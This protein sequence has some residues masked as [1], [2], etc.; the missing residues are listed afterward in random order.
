MTFSV[1]SAIDRHVGTLEKERE[2]DGKWHPSSISGCARQAVYNFRGIPRTDER[3]PKSKRILRIGH[4]LHQF[5]QDAVMAEVGSTIK[6]FYAEVKIDIPELNI[7]GSVD[8]VLELIDGTWLVLEFKTISANGLK[9]AK[10]LPKPEHVVQ[11]SCYI[12]ALREHGSADAGIPPLGD[13]LRSC[14]VAYVE[15]Q[16][17][18]I[19]EY[20]VEWNEELREDLIARAAELNWYETGDELP[21]RIAADTKKGGRHWLCNYCDWRTLCWSGGE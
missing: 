15:K 9:Y 18:L 17:L 20:T 5:A 2:P 10:E 8:G 21:D 19:A 16:D 13:K 12:H 3:D 7:T 14:I 6:A 4:I 11:V 1:L